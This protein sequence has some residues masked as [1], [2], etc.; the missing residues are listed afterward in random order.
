MTDRIAALQRMLKSRPDD[1]RMRFGLALEYEKAG[2]LEE[3]AEELRRYLEATEDE[4]NAWG[5][6]GDALRRL[7]REDEAREAVET[8]I[9]QALKHGHPTMAEEFRELLESW[10]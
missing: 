6:L 3:A 7:G 1:P 4:G 2:R 9:Q 8:G 10:D 5:R